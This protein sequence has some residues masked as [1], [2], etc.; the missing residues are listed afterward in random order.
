MV[1][2]VP[3]VVHNMR[4]GMQD[5]AI[6][7]EASRARIKGH[8]CDNGVLIDHEGGWQTQYCHLR[9][10]SVKV[11]AGDRVEAGSP[12]GL[13]GL[14]G[15]TEFPHVHL[16]VRKDGKA[17]DPFTSQEISAGCWEGGEA[18]LAFG[19][20]RALRGSGAVQCRLLSRQA[21][22]AAIRNGKHDEGP[23][24]ASS[25]ALVLWVDIFGVQVED[26]LW[27]RITGPDG[28][29]LFEHVEPIEKT[30]ARRFVFAGKKLT[31]SAWPAGS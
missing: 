25:P 27:F 23:L 20:V 26:K 3:G 18:A 30:Q 24:A 16:T 21:G 19:P 14:S 9:Q 13:V 8:E 15:K 10:G 6:T 17:I 12:L 1:A 5:V 22:F 29:L 4:D 11:K 31:A 28:K 7:D 2:S